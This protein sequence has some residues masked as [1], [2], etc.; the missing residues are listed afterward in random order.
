MRI[1]GV[2]DSNGCHVDVSKS[3]EQVKRYARLNEHDKI[4]CRFNY[5]AIVLYEWNGKRWIE[6]K[7]RN[8]N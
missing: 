7:S 3:L 6:L 1:Y 2:L 4:S 5:N 8:N